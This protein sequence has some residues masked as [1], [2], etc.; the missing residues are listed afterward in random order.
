MACRCYY[1]Y[2]DDDNVDLPSGGVSSNHSSTGVA[3]NHCFV[4]YGSTHSC[5][6][7][8]ISGCSSGVSSTVQSYLASAVA[9]PSTVGEVAWYPDSG[10]TT[11]LTNG[12]ACVTNS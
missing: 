6:C 4:E 11:H 10:A 3:A 7:G 5:E 8:S 12:F 2:E 1:I 9:T